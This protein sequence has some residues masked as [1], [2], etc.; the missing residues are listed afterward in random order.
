MNIVEKKHEKA[1]DNYNRKQMWIIATCCLWIYNVLD[2]ILFFPSFDKEIFKRAVPV[3]STN[4]QNGT[5][6]LKWS[7]PI[8]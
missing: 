6:K 1:D 4:I 3:M 5:T 7:M 8:R 2:A